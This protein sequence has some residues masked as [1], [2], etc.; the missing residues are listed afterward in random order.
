MIHKDI[1]A[2]A[3]IWEKFHMRESIRSVPIKKVLI[4]LL[5]LLLV[6]SAW[7]IHTKTF[8]TMVVKL[9]TAKLTQ[10]ANS[11]LDAGVVPDGISYFTYDIYYCEPIHTVEFETFAFG[12]APS[13]AYYGFYYSPENKPV[14][15]ESCGELSF[16]RDGIGWLWEEE[17]GDNWV[18]TEKIKDHWYWFERHY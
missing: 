5:I 9:D 15:Y 1:V 11:V 2:R 14:G 13:S 17:N 10:I 8:V 16:Q 6:F 7:F 18:Y 3:F 4:T 12:L